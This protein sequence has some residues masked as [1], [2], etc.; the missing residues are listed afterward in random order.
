MRAHIQRLP[1][2]HRA[3]DTRTRGIPLS[4]TCNITFT[5]LISTLVL[6]GT[7]VRWLW[8]G[9]N[10]GDDDALKVRFLA[11]KIGTAPRASRHRHITHVC[12]RCTSLAVHQ[13]QWLQARDDMSEPASGRGHCRLISATRAPK[14]TEVNAHL[15]VHTIGLAGSH[16]YAA[17]STCACG[18]PP[19]FARGTRRAAHLALK[20][21]PI[22]EGLPT[23]YPI[24]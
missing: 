23:W 9:A 17:R 6:L 5:A 19:S 4:M 3:L 13:S 16:Q 10:C 18:T 1:W 12:P 21:A 7:A 15:A 2:P 11:F 8:A 24:Q 20:H 22:S 14:R